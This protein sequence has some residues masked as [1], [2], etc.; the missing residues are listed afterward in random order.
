MTNRKVGN[1]IFGFNNK[2]KVEII[3]II[4]FKGLD[5]FGLAIFS[6]FLDMKY[7]DVKKINTQQKISEVSEI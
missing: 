1:P 4:F 5:K 7:I 6:E 2:G 3:K